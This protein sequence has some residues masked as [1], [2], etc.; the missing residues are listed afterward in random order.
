MRSLA[1][2]R[3]VDGMSEPPVV[4]HPPHVVVRPPALDEGARPYRRVDILG[5]TVGKAY[6]L[7]D[8]IEFMRRAGLEDVHYEEPELVLWQGGVSDVWK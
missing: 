3:N 4:H 6:A 7:A 8:V 5:E 2:R 1:G